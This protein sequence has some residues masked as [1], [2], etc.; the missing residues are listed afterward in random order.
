MKKLILFA[1]LTILAAYVDSAEFA[2]EKKTEP[3]EDIEIYKEINGGLTRTPLD[4]KWTDIDL[5]L[6]GYLFANLLIGIQISKI[7]I[8]QMMQLL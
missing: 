4:S 3:L 1:T 2:I 7:I 6:F 8:I 5:Q